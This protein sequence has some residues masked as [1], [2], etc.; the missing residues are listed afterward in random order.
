[1]KR[2]YPDERYP[3]VAF[4]IASIEP[5]IGRLTE[6]FPDDPRSMIQLLDEISFKAESDLAAEFDALDTQAVTQA[7]SVPFLPDDMID[8]R[9]G[10]MQKV[11][12]EANQCYE[13]GCYNACA[14]MIRRLVE[15]LIVE[16][17]ER[18]G[19]SDR[20]KKDCSQKNG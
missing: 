7:N 14:A 17:Y 13:R 8:T 3:R 9:F 6:T 15:N 1:M 12:W 20:I 18:Q 10:V 16:C 4:Q 19:I 5:L 11:L 2:D